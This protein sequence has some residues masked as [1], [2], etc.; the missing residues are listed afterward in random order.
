MDI[1]EALNEIPE[2]QTSIAAI[3]AAIWAVIEDMSWQELSRRFET[4][5]EDLE[6]A[7][8]ILQAAGIDPQTKKLFAQ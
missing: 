1:L 8:A 6:K 4:N 2:E 7:R 3:Q 5:P